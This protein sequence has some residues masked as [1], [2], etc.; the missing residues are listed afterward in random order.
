M[1][2][3]NDMRAFLAQCSIALDKMPGV[4]PIRIGEYCQRIETKVMALTT[5]LDVQDVCG[6][7]Q[8]SAGAKAGNEAVVHAMWELFTARKVGEL[9][10]GGRF[11]RLQ[12]LEQASCTL[13]LLGALATP[14]S[15]SLQLLSRLH[16]D[17]VEEPVFWEVACTVEPGGYHPRLPTSNADVYSRSLSTDLSFEGFEEAQAELV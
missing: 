12:F 3:W 17:P 9:P 14:L 2:P 4:C 5:G 15:V 13:E 16:H 11:K 8:L 10:P 7:D 1:V 6:V